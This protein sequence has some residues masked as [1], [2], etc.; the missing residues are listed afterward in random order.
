MSWIPPWICSTACHIQQHCLGYSK[1]A[2]MKNASRVWRIMKNS[3]RSHSLNFF[4]SRRRLWFSQPV[5]GFSV[6]QDTEA[7][8]KS[9]ELICRAFSFHIVDLLQSILCGCKQTGMYSTYAVMSNTWILDLWCHIPPDET[10]DNV[11]IH[12]LLTSSYIG[13]NQHY[14]TLANTIAPNAYHE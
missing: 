9:R 3:Q 5:V 13:H 1:L 4:Y 8:E 7:L 14:V 11:F 10:H 12:N 2:C 6:A